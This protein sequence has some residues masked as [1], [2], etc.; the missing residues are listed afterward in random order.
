[1]LKSG[2]QAALANFS[3]ALG[4]HEEMPTRKVS[5]RAEPVAQDLLTGETIP[6]QEQ[7]ELP[8]GGPSAKATGTHD[9]GQIQKSEVAPE[10]TNTQQDR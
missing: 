1:M 6:L 3:S 5:D 10:M 8:N 7:V 2:F 9:P 4:S